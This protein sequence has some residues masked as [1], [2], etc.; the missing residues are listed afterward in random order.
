MRVNFTSFYFSLCTYSL[1]CV[2][3]SLEPGC[4][5][6]SPTKHSSPQIPR[7][8]SVLFFLFLAAKQVPSAII[9]TQYPICTP[10]LSK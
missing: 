7:A 10:A 1:S 3:L 8:L 2:I 4:A 6:P 9:S 5:P